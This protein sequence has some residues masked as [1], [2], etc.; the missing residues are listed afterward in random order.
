MQ[1]TTKIAVPLSCSSSITQKFLVKRKCSA[2]YLRP[3]ARPRKCDGAWFADRAMGINA[4]QSVV[5]DLCARGGLEGF[6]TN[7]SL[8]ATSATRM[9]NANVQE[10][11]IQE[12]TGHRSLAVRGYKKTSISQKRTA[13]EALYSNGNVRY[14]KPRVFCDYYEENFEM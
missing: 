10:Q 2:L 8:R 4:L 6:Y 11:V 1:M 7:H 9:Y 13:S 3:L 14:T 5:K 12:V